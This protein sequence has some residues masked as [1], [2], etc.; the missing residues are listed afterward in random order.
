MSVCPKCQKPVEEGAAICSACG[1]AMPAKSSGTLD[2]GAFFVD[3]EDSPE[4]PSPEAESPKSDAAAVKAPMPD[5]KNPQPA[6]TAKPANEQ[7][8]GTLGMP[9]I[10]EPKRTSGKTSQP[11]VQ[12][13]ATI[14]SVQGSDAQA[15]VQL[16]DSASPVDGTAEYDD[17]ELSAAQAGNGKSGTAGR[18]K[19]LWGGAAGS[20]QNP[21]HTL[22][23]DDALATD[24]VFAKVA[25]RVLV[26]DTA[27]D[28]VETV[29]TASTSQPDKRARVQE[30]I[31]IACKGGSS[32]AADYD[33][34]GFLGQGGM[35]VVLKAHQKAIGRDVAIKMIQPSAGK[36]SASASSTNAQKKKF[37][38]EAQITGK[39]DHPNIVPIYE[40]GIS[41]EVL[42][43]SMKMI[44][45]TEWKDVIG[46]NKREDNLDIFM[47]VADAMAFAHQKRV[48][49]RDLKPENVMLG[50][51]G[52]VLVTDWGCAVDLS[53]KE[54]FTGAG[55]PPWMAPEMAEHNVRKIGPCSDIYLLG[56]I[57]YQIIAGYPPHPGQTIFEC[58]E[59]AQKNIILPLE[60]EDPLLNIALQAMETNPEDR[61]ATVEAM[62]DAIR[63]YRRHAE[64]ITLSER[65]EAL[66]VQATQSKDFERFSRT[67][68]GFQDAIELWPQNTAAIS[69]LASARLA[70]GQCAY[71]KGSYDLCLQALD[72]SVPAEAELYAK[73]EKAKKVAEERERR[74]KTM[75]KVL[76]AVILLGL[77]VSSI[78]AAVAWKQRNDAV[79][80]RGDAENKKKDAEFNLAEAE[81]QKAEAFRQKGI[82]DMKTEEAQMQRVVADMK[83]AEAQM[84]REVADMKTAEAQMQREIADMKTEEAQMQ[85]EIAEMKTAEAQVQK[86]IA[87]ERTAEVELGSFQSK[88]ALSLGQVR[89]RDVKNADQSLNNLVDSSSYTALNAKGNQPNFKNWALNRVNLLSNRDLLA[90]K[91][92]GDVTSVAFAQNANVGVVAT[93][94]AGT[95]QGML[96]IVELKDGK[97]HV[98]R[99]LPPTEARVTSVSISPSGD[100]IIYSLS[101]GVG[102]D[103]SAIFKLNL[104]DANGVPQKV[105]NSGDAPLKSGASLQTFV[106]TED[107]VIGGINGGLW[108]WSRTTPDWQDSVP[109]QIKNIRGRL[110]SLQLLDAAN[111]LV[112]TEINQKLVVQSVK[113]EGT[114]EATTVEFEASEDFM[115]DDLSAIAYADGKIILGTTTGR[116]FTASL[117]AGALKVG[118][119]YF[120][121]LPQMH[122]AE[123]K[124]IR[125]HQDGKSML[126][127]AAEPVVN[128]WTAS[129]TQLAGW[130]FNTDLAGTPE[131][132]GG[133][134][135]MNSPNLVLGVGESGTAIVWDIP[136]QKQ[137][138]QLRRVDADGN[139]LQFA[140]P[141]IEVVTSNDNER[142][143]S[144]HRD[145]TVDSWNL[146]T[147]ET[148]TKTEVPDAPESINA[149]L[150]YVGH[151][152]GASFVD[153]SIDER[154]GIMVTSARMPQEEEVAASVENKPEK[155]WEFCKW[156][157]RT[158]M[159]LG[160]WT[161]V[162]SA[163]QEIS[164]AGKGQLIL[165]ARNDE[166][167][168]KEAK[169]N[170]NVSISNTSLGSFFGVVH[171]LQDNLMMTVKSN[172]AA[173]ILDTNQPDGG[174]SIPGFRIDYDNPANSG[175]RTDD[176]VPLVGQWSP[177]GNRFYMI[178][179]SGRITEL[180][181]EDARLSRGRDLRSKELEELGIDL[182]LESQD[183]EKKP[184]KV[185][186]SSRWQVDMKV[187]NEGQYNLLY[188]GIR[189]PGSE[190][191]MRL[192]R[193]AIPKGEGKILAA[194]DDQIV[195]KPLVLTDE[196]AP[197]FERAPL[198]KITVPDREI[199]ATR[200]IGENSYLATTGG[201]VYQVSAA[202]VEHVFGRPETIAGCG[203]SDANSV[204]TL[205]QGGIMWRGDLQ[206]GQWTWKPL[207]AAPLGARKISMSP[208]GKQLLILIEGSNG[209][210]ELMIAD[211]N[212]GMGSES[213]A[214][215]QCGTWDGTGELVYAKS[216]GSIELR[217]NGAPRFLGKMQDG[218]QVASLHFFVEPFTAKDTRRWVMA[219]GKSSESA[220][221]LI[222]YFS[223]SENPAPADKLETA[224]IPGGM[225]LLACSPMDGIFVVGGK[226]TVQIH[227]ASPSLEQYGKDPLFSLEGH[228]GAEIESLTFSAD[229]KT[230]IS[231]DSVNR[232]YGWLSDDKLGGIATQPTQRP[233]VQ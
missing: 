149:A 58:I 231:T 145:G 82:A 164:L 196:E 54:S 105:A 48:I 88:L 12:L 70:Y 198:L 123:I 51:F 147:G 81:R 98:I 193:V 202:G 232:L 46:K 157:L 64:S 100:E 219:H 182:S 222:Q 1:Q 118:P 221:D 28:I 68:F 204:V 146:I 151:S 139:A 169:R 210:S 161:E 138:Q 153:M 57:L 134:A 6:S 94:K 137:R 14:D 176:E 155:V 72:R 30:C 27:I 168:I 53:R 229:G 50:P 203:N 174:L 17:V 9:E 55:S 26:T 47:K 2:A 220:P 159:M 217:T 186:L 4:S 218:H 206:D 230:L 39:L 162:A 36:S 20:S 104:G 32:E 79:E 22:K 178:W 171:P 25:Q 3:A 197:A 172:G 52:E 106:M 200:T 119:Q 10:V 165:Y 175:L 34:T 67:I 29:G 201:T 188:L 183:A 117:A 190:G 59:A 35:G 115:R 163:E 113:L 213:I 121:V 132:V 69:G 228:A 15:T 97:P 18:L 83:T 225:N 91:P 24:S 16:N 73:A 227:F 93:V 63:E 99:E 192:A 75:R 136:R 116:L 167:L 23:S 33:L 224:S 223:L 140:S 152:P 142:A 208:D 124:T 87:E 49:H 92:L 205:H 185:R 107:K 66:L 180:V 89:Q 77:G 189:Y 61:Y 170:G 160:R 31:S 179:E 74:L 211:S 42:F 158:G 108:V 102:T 11:T 40:L 80:A 62:Q 144:I 101:E 120:E 112:L 45:G 194:K 60:I 128:V 21:M 233:G 191:R 209:L 122:N 130:Q 187:R 90:E 96:Q 125:V 154:A 214:D 212:T 13:D 129:T 215:V 173:R 37:F 65:S 109:T 150:S 85:R 127:S 131:N 226:G 19:R 148:L 86:G 181:W 8:Q 216:D 143:I 7:A 126:T 71:D 43:Y 103:S 166:T 133:V 156:D 110:L 195:A 184:T 76:A 207:T 41:N 135:F 141:V 95:N 5:S 111:A 177:E 114:Q 84:Q 78:M 56:A 199:V 44:I 38:Y